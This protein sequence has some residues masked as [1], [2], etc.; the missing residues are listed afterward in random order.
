MRTINSS[1]EN[2]E[3]AR[4]RADRPVLPILLFVLGELNE[5]RISY[6][7]WKSTRR[8]QS[9][10]AGDG[11]LDL[12]IGREDRQR[13]IAILL[14]HG[15]KA[16]ASVAGRD[17][18][19]ISSFLGYDELSGQLVHLHLHF[20]LIV[21]ERLLKNYRIPWEE[22]V[23]ARA[24]IHP[25]FPIRVLDPLSEALLVIVRAS[26]ELRRLDPVSFRCWKA[27]RDKFASDRA[28]LAGRIDRSMLSL[29]AIERFGGNLAHDVV[30]AFYSGRP[31]ESLSDL[32]RKIARYFA[33]Y[34]TY[35]TAEAR[36]RGIGRALFWL[37]GNLNKRFF[38]LPRPWNR[39]APGGGSVV[40]VIGV[41][42]S[43]KTT[44]VATIRKWLG[45]EIDV[46]PIYF[47]TGEGR[48]SLLMRPF[49]LLVPLISRFIRAKPKGASHGTISLRPPG[50]L[51]SA[52]LMV[53]ASIVVIEKRRK[54]IAARRGASRGLIVLAD[55]YPQNEIL[56][57]NDG[58]LLIRAAKLPRWIAQLETAAYARVER[59]APDLVIKLEVTPETAAM[60]EPNMNPAI[61][62][63][64]IAA[65]KQLRFHSP[66]VKSVDAEQPLAEVLA[67]VKREIWR[68][69]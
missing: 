60:R 38:H 48:P 9:A 22:V 44:V 29:F 36:G 8:V 56:G 66:R 69:L 45:S 17:H 42:G 41:D 34:R 25:T 33:P 43:G 5:Q 3:I 6:C 10:L 26:L 59:L 47:G 39:R 32:R 52:M 37:A 50:R 49:K 58:P 24:V 57:F 11:D 31:L 65:V 28:E 1:E 30:E 23:L 20:R 7:C 18:P 68:L 61:I 35:T 51:Y 16:F 27:T 53:W 67:S 2:G 62:E 46:M 19:A 63:E 40:A 13:A 21:G 54:L 64:R 12:L 4:C 55:R 14:E 15:F